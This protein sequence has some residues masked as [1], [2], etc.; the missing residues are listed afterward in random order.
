MLFAVVRLTEDQ[1]EL[2]PATNRMQVPVI[3]TLLC[4]GNLLIAE[5]AGYVHITIE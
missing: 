3:V 2:L 4:G 1:I 5:S